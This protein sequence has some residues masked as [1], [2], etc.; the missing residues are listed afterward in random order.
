MKKSLSNKA[1]VWHYD[2]IAGFL[3]FSIAIA[4]FFTFYQ[5]EKSDVEYEALKISNILMTEEGIVNNHKLNNTKLQDIT[6]KN[7]NELKAIFNVKN[8]FIILLNEQYINGLT[9]FNN[10]KNLAK[11]QRIII[12]NKEPSRIEV[13]VW[14]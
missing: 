4:M 10:A 9:D 7:Y 11:I 8:K 6:N 5:P 2:F 14:E 12:N 1:Q 3:L 13:Y